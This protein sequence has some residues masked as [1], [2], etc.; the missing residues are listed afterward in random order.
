MSLM[1]VKVSMNF[2]KSKLTIFFG[3][4][5][6]YEVFEISHY[7]LVVFSCEW[8]MFSSM[9][10]DPKDIAIMLIKMITITTKIP[11]PILDHIPVD[12]L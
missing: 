3:N 12:L 1:L 10:G 8:T 6:L 7:K 4:T 11:I 9:S 2:F 5:I